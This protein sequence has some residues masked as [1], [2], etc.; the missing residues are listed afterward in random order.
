MA[1]TLI[2]PLGGINGADRVSLAPDIW[3]ERMPSHVGPILDKA[4][5]S[6]VVRHP[7]NYS[8][9]LVA[10]IDYLEA[11]DDERIKEFVQHIVLLL[12]LWKAGD[13]YFNVIIVDHNGW[14]L[15]PTVSITPEFSMIGIFFFVG[16]THRGLSVRYSLG[17]AEEPALAEFIAA[18][19]D[20]R[21]LDQRSYRFFFTAF[22]EPY[23]DDRFLKNAIGLENLLCSDA[24][25]P[26]NLTYKFVD[27]GCYLLSRT[28]P[29]S[30]G[31]T[32]FVKP[33]KDIYKLRSTLVHSSKKRVDWQEATTS[34]AL[35]NSER[36]LRALL[37]FVLENPE[38]ESAEA[39]DA[40]KRETYRAP[41]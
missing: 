12:R 5:Q 2:A 11:G 17:A 13:V 34:E 23:T 15:S 31:A 21:L 26:S 19:R 33:L 1:C 35:R 4:R 27:R 16:W 22:H 41:R 20:K 39:I 6:Y 3:I 18:H 37:R 30:S 7:P 36:F 32:E 9:C 28:I 10:R 24:E 38:C 25:E 8:H 29:D 14:Y 40:A